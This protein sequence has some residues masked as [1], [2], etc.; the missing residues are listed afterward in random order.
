MMY[1]VMVF[2]DFQCDLNEQSQYEERMS[3]YNCR[4]L[5]YD[6]AQ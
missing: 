2:N 5:R 4:Y 1:N 3:I 6:N